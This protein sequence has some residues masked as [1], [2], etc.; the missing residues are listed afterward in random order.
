MPF[1]FSDKKR[2]SSDGEVQRIY[3]CECGD[4]CVETKHSRQNF[5][6]EEFI[7]L[8]RSIVIKDKK[9]SLKR[10]FAGDFDYNQY[11]K[12]FRF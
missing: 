7:G 9:N 2:K 4:I 11:K 8:L 6:P 5:S 1:D 10:L 3:V 12:R